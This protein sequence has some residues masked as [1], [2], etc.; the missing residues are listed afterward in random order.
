MKKD[1]SIKNLRDYKKGTK[2]LLEEKK[3]DKKVRVKKK[4][5]R[6]I[7][8][9]FIIIM[10]FSTLFMSRYSLITNLEYEIQSL[11]KELDNKKNDKKELILELDN[12]S[13][14]G[15]IEQTAKEK[16]NMIYP[17]Q[18]QIVYINLQ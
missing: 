4:N 7:T 6:F 3:T 16:L 13:K 17:T 2:T 18:E 9:L 1:D 8:F 10:M 14:S 12:L 11:N 15:F 5:Y